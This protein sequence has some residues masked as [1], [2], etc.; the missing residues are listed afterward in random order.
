M[1][2][3]ANPDGQICADRDVIRSRMGGQCG[4]VHFSRLQ[5]VRP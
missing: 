4:I 3:N 1:Y 2:L 5:A